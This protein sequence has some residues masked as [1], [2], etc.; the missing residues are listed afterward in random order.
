M[1][2]F[3]LMADSLEQRL[4]VHAVYQ[5]QEMEQCLWQNTILQEIVFGQKANQE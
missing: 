2:T 3:M 4:L 1:G 5:M